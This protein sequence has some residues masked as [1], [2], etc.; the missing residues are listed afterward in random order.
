MNLANFLTSLRLV[1]IPVLVYVLVAEIENYRIIAAILFAFSGLTDFFDGLIARKYDMVSNLGRV[2]D[3]LADK[4]TIIA[5]FF[6]LLFKGV[7]PLSAGLI[8]LGR[9]LVIFIATSIMYLLGKDLVHPSNLGKVSAA[10]LYIVALLI[11]FNVGAVGNT[12]VWIG[13]TLSII[14]AADYFR[15][16]YTSFYK[17]T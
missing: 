10:T 8:I 15:I 11:I 3:P 17:T 14:S 1:L 12:L 2:L 4:L 13:A 5:V 16:A 7:I 9:E 6:A